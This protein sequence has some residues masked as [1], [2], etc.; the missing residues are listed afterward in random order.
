M[1]TPLTQNS[2]ATLNLRWVTEPPIRQ[3]TKE[4]TGFAINQL[5][6]NLTGWDTVKDAHLGTVDVTD[7]QDP[8]RTQ[9]ERWNQRISSTNS[10]LKKDFSDETNFGYFVDGQ[11][12]GIMTIDD[13]GSDNSFY[14]CDLVTH[15]GSGEAGGILIEHAAQ[16]SDS[17][18]GSGKL[19]L[20][21]LDEDA[22]R[23]YL[24]LGFKSIP[25][26]ATNSM[27]LDPG[28]TA[29]W[30]KLDGKWRIAKHIGKKYIG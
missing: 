10:M 28:Q 8:K 27:M 21:A 18:G 16:W 6:G 5:K 4:E 23:A 26:K 25:Q 1:S 14:I 3:L 30:C 12:I 15:P 11:P 19:E 20:W 2:K 7:W 17:H 22:L 9:E 29:S 24:A 13:I